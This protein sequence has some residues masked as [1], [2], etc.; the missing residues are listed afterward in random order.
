MFKKNGIY[1]HVNSCQYDIL[2]NQYRFKIKDEHYV[3]YTFIDKFTHSAVSLPCKG[4]IKEIDLCRWEHIG[5][6]I[7]GVFH[8][9]GEE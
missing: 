8:I 7:D 5:D 4:E 9:W 6:K 3:K 1:R 2:I